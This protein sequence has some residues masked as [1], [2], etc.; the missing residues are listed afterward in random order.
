MI[1]QKKDRP[2]AN[3]A[4]SL[5]QNKPRHYNKIPLDFKAINRAALGSL[6]VLLARWL[7]DGK[8][9]NGEWV[10]RNPRRADNH[11]G[12]FKINLTTGRW[13]DFATGDRGGDII[14]L[15]AFLSGT[16]QGEAAHR[17]ARMFGMGGSHE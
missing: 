8:R 17:L 9:V 2:G 6:P 12:S 4:A 11:A 16:S 3:G 1:T 13:A 10:A 5:Q 15:A 7:P 14:S